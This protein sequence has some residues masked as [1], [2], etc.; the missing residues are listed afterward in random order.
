MILIAL[1][2]GA[3]LDLLSSARCM[4][5]L[6]PG[7]RLVHPK[8]LAQNAWDMARRSPWFSSIHVRAIDWNLVKIVHLLEITRL[9]HNP[10]LTE[11]LTRFDGEIISHSR[12]SAS[13]PFQVQEPM[14][15]SQS[16][17]AH[18]TLQLFK[19]G[20]KISED[21]AEL[22]LMG[23]IERTGA[24]LSSHVTETDIEALNRL[25]NFAIPIR[26]VSNQVVLGFREG[27]HG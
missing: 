4:T 8:R 23:I 19:R 11:I 25:R 9:P 7:A 16:L 2:D 10:E 14:A 26:R 20:E 17:T 12:Q 15:Y 3:D 6:V 24:F 1:P 21:D 27:Q 18:F 22:L 5:L 13:L